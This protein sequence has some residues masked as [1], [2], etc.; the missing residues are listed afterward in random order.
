MGLRVAECGIFV[1]GK[2]RLVFARVEKV[3]AKA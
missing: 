2:V 3:V 1:V